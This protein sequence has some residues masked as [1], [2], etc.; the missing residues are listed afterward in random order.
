MILNHFNAHTSITTFWVGSGGPQDL[1]GANG[2][3]SRNKILKVLLDLFLVL[4][5][6]L[7]AGENSEFPESRFP[8]ML[9]FPL[10]SPQLSESVPLHKLS[11]LP[12]CDTDRWESWETLNVQH[13]QSAL[14]IRQKQHFHI[15]TLR[16][17]LTTLIW[18]QAACTVICVCLPHMLCSCW[19]CMAHG[20]PC[21]ALS[22]PRLASIWK[23]PSRSR[24][25]WGSEPQSQLASLTW[26]HKNRTSYMWKLY[27]H[28]LNI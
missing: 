7:T 1:Q 6:L 14:L 9:L 18:N 13:K 8:L 25:L 22:C 19:A 17:R 15:K 16:H 24:Y 20:L 4:F 26:L 27:N 2:E 21:A 5:G 12:E 28:N 23:S 11:L 10:Q 3:R